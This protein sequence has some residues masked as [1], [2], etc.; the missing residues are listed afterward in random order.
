MASVLVVDDDPTIRG[1]LARALESIGPT[2]TVEQAAN[3]VDA[4]RVLAAKKFDL[5]LLD[6]H[7]AG[8]DGMHVLRIVTTKDGPNRDTPIVVITAD[9]SEQVR[10]QSL[11]NRAMM[12]VTKPLHITTL[13]ALV[14]PVLRRAVTRATPPEPFPPQPSDAPPKRP[15]IKR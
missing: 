12:F 10:A 14:T 2:P 7:M 8:I 15:G 3:G 11:S 4:L 13:L 6:V 5:V 1:M 9:G